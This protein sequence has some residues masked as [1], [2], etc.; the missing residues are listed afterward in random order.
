MSSLDR[1]VEVAVQAAAWQNGDAELFTETSRVVAFGFSAADGACE[2]PVISVP[3]CPTFL[4]FSV[5]VP[6]KGFQTNNKDNNKSTTRNP[7]SH[8]NYGVHMIILGG[9]L[10]GVTG[11]SFNASPLRCWLWI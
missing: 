4:V 5:P 8:S 10:L 6:C 2:P 7:G 11:I 3:F 9:L 1:R